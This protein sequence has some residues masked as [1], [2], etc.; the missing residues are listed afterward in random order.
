MSAAWLRYLLPWVALAGCGVDSGD[1]VPLRAPSRATFDLEA[2]PL[3]A[4][5]C[6]DFACHGKADRPLS[7][8]A[9]GRMRLAAL[10]SGSASPLTS[11]EVDA[12]YSATRG[13]LDAS[14]AT[15]TTLIRE[16]LG[17][18]GGHKGGAVFAAPSDPQCRAIVRWIEATP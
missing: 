9:T 4:K 2:G 11:A 15:D 13:F 5:R 18:G 12:N 3:L 6:G 10:D 16:A 1:S 7:L 17:G 14:R 8:F